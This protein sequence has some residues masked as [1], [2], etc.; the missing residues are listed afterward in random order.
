[1][2]IVYFCDE[3]PPRPHGGIGTF[4][5]TAAQGMLHR[6]HQV[7]VVGLGDR[8]GQTDVGGVKVITLARNNIRFVGNLITRVKLRNYLASI[9]RA[10][11]ADIIEV[12]DYMGMLPF[13]V[14]GAKVVVRLHLSSTAIRSHAQ[15][16]TSRGIAY[17]EKRTLIATPHWI[18]VSH[19]VLELTEST[20]SITARHPRV[21]YNPA[22][23]VPEK[24]PEFGGLPTN[25][26]LFA[27]QVSKRKGALI[28]AE[29]AKGLMTTR[30]DLHLVY[31]GGPSPHENERSL[32]EEIFAL[33][34]PAA[35]QRVH[36]LGHVSR[37]KVLACMRKA[38]VFVFPS[39]LEALGLVVLEAMNCGTPV[40]CTNIPPGPEMVVD[41][42][43]GLLADPSS[44]ED[45]REKIARVLDDPSLAKRL[46]ENARKMLSTQF[47]L[48]SC[49]S[50]TEEFYLECLNHS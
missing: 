29:A 35:A 32:P 49:I 38:S 11:E 5:E 4:V 13:G 17:Y 39:S 30:S 33:L 26:I 15:I 44:P 36:F 31:A 3:Y 45:F 22:P 8:N 16:P 23:S 19:S 1:M 40:V 20:F 43:S 28:A 46:T 37:E 2:K 12:P 27:G 50:S 14:P 7:R 47:S 41:G 24:L 42:V 48:E 9:A 25:Y 6:G 21:I 10:G 34:G 18:A